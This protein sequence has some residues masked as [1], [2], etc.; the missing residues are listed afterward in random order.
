[1]ER[2]FVR[3]TLV[4]ALDPKATPSGDRLKVRKPV[5]KHLADQGEWVERDSYWL[6][7]LA[8]KDVE[9]TTP[10]ADPESKPAAGGTAGGTAVAVKRS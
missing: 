9:E 1:M 5:G 2:I 4:P 10:P 8:D 3:P 7:R 6:R